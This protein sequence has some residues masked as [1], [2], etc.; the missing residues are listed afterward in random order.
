MTQNRVSPRLR[1]ATAPVARPDAVVQGDRWRITVLTDGLLRLEWADDGVFE[2]RA[3]AFAVHR[4]LP[5]PDFR[6]VEG[7]NLEIVTERLHLIYDR[8]AFSPRG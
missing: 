3:S 7:E 2:D 1:L 6:V 5:V 8:R 4:D